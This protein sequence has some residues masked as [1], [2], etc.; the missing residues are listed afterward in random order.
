[1]ILIVCPSKREA[2]TVSEMFHFMGLLS[3]P[4]THE[5]ASAEISYM[6]RSVLI[7]SPER[8]YSEFDFVKKLRSYAMDIP[9]F[10]F[11][12]PKKPELYDKVFSQ[13]VTISKVIV[14]MRKYCR[15]HELKLPGTYQIAGIDISATTKDPTYFF[16][17]I[18]FTKTELMILRALIR[19]YP[20][21]AKSAEIIKYAFKTSKRPEATSLRTHISFI[22]RK[23][24]EMTGQN[25][26]TRLDPNGYIILTPEIRERKNAAL[27]R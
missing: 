3:T 13:S 8:L 24:R 27:A 20:Y 15:K 25:L 26:I 21:P 16:D 1:M 22:N 6:Y 9:I 7:S 23:F 2:V 11:G 17:P 19:L 4:V 12:E 18:S 10:A 14:A 5:E